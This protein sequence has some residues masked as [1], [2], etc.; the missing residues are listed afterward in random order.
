M[1]ALSAILVTGS[2]LPASLG[3]HAASQS[4]AGADVHPT[5]AEITRVVDAA[6]CL[7]NQRRADHGRRPLRVN[8]HLATAATRHARDMVRHRYFSHV[9][10]NGT[11]L[12][13]RLRRSGYLRSGVF[14]VAEDI[15]WGMGNPAS[16]RNMV[17][18]WMASPPHR[19]ALLDPKMREIGMGIVAGAPNGARHNAGTYVMDLGRRHGH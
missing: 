14:N 19:A 13:G 3:A 6:L 7:V 16:P 18:S 1:P 2:L 11:T 5:K 9:S 8:S 4:C 12:E 10:R 17:R 15:G